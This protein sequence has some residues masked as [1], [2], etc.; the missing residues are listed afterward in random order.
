[1]ATLLW[2][3]VIFIIII[4]IV[5]GIVVISQFTLSPPTSLIINVIDSAGITL[6]NTYIPE[7]A[8]YTL[9]SGTSLSGYNIDIANI[10]SSSTIIYLYSITGEYPDVFNFDAMKTIFV[11]YIDVNGI[12]RFALACKIADLTGFIYTDDVGTL[13]NPIKYTGLWTWTTNGLVRFT[14]ISLKLS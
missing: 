11:K 8:I 7:N 9:T 4:V 2:G 1:M 14:G 5:V 3:I 12:S 13:V 10:F 6:Y